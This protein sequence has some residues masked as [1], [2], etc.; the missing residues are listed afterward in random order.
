[1]AALIDC[2]RRY[3]RQ[4][5]EMPSGPASEQSQIRPP[6]AAR[7]SGPAEAATP[8]HVT[9]N[10]S[11]DRPTEPPRGPAELVSKMHR[12]RAAVSQAEIARIIRAAKQAGAAQIEV[13]LND[14]STVLI[15]LQPDNS[16]AQSEEIVL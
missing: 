11:G 4:I 16:L 12:R 14:L 6:P 5:M 7:L 15:R 8:E 3:A 2:E 10:S 13:R 1:M 9:R